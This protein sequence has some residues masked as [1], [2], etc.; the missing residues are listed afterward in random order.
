[1][2][3]DYNAYYVSNLAFSISYIIKMFGPKIVQIFGSTQLFQTWFEIS[4][5][6]HISFLSLYSS[7]AYNLVNKSGLPKLNLKPLKYIDN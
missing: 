1:M 2:H 4:H 7:L 3:H 6:V 5:Y